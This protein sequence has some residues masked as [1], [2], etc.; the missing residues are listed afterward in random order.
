M[1]VPVLHGRRNRH[2]ARQRQ[3]LSGADSTGASTT[4]TSFPVLMVLP[5]N[6]LCLF[7]RS[8]KAGFGRGID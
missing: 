2:D 5:W 4:R 6:E 1:T 8:G 3:D 7:L